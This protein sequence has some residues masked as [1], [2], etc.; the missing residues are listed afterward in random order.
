MKSNKTCVVKSY[1]M[2]MKEIK[3]HLSRWRSRLCQILSKVSYRVNTT[4][5]NTA[6]AR[7]WRTHGKGPVRMGEGWLELNGN[8]A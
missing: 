6:P 7:V 4:P 5:V 1:K 2:R 8:V 3:D